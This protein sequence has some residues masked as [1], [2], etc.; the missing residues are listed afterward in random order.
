MGRIHQPFS[1]TFF[2][3]FSRVCKFECNTTSGWLNRQ[4]GLANQKLCYIQMVLNTEKS[5]EQDKERSKE[6]LVNTT[7]VTFDTV[8]CRVVSVC[9]ARRD[10]A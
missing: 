8:S 2:V 10:T 9:S 5:G 4:S 3:L 1:R 6:W 7:P